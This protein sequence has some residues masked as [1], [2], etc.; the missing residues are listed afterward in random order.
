MPEAT[1]H[2]VEAS[3]DL[4]LGIG[5]DHK[6]AADTPECYGANIAVSC[7]NSSLRLMRP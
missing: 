4:C 1:K 3:R 6:S 7:V 2:S 5:G